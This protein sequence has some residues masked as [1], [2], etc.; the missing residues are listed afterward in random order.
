M[1]R[2]SLELD[3][4]NRPKDK[5]H[6]E[7]RHDDDQLVSLDVSDLEGVEGAVQLV[8][9]EARSLAALLMAQAEAAER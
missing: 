4:Y 5:I 3:Y 9:E 8:P 2:L 6:V 7:A 1:T